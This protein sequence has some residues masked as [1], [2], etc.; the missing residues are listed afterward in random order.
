MQLIVVLI[1]IGLFGTV[2]YLVFKSKPKPL[3][4]PEIP[5]VKK[6]LEEQVTFYQGL[7][8]AEKADFE[9]RLLAFLEKV[10]ITGVKT[11]VSDADRV[12]V[13]AAAI[14]PIFAFKGWEYPN[15]HEVLVYPGSF[16]TDFAIRGEG[17]NVLGMVG[18]GPMKDVMILSKQDLHQDFSDPHS[19][20]NTAVHE[21]VHLID[22][23]DGDTDGCPR[24]FIPPQYVVPWLKRI[25]QEIRLIKMGESDINPYATTNEA[26]FLAVAAEYF[27]E[28]PHRMQE[29][30]PELYDLLLQVFMPGKKQATN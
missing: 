9:K 26:E 12:L 11:E 17:R 15:I 20:S 2:F 19:H 5:V 18:N 23:A 6:T 4:L 30:H 7:N 24:T 10:R 28:Q 13:A 25:H 1:L 22:A 27:F 3:P 21:F 14:I 8:D 29:K 16:N